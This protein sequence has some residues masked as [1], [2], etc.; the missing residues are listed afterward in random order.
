MHSRLS[1]LA[2]A[3]VLGAAAIPSAAWGQAQV[4]QSIAGTRLDV[5]ARG[6]VNRVPDI[7]T[8]STGVTTRAATASAAISEAA[9][10]MAAIRAELKRSGIADRDIQTSNLSLNPQYAYAEGRAPRLTGYEASNQL[11]VRFRNIAD[12]G[13]VI[14]ALVRAGANQINGP[15]LSIEDP[16]SALDEARAS[17][18]ARG[19]AEAALYARALGMRVVRV[20]SVSEGGGNYPVPPPMPVMMS[21]ERSSDSKI[22]PG[23]QKLSVALMMTFELQ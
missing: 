1:T 16:Q 6:E 10:R 8:V 14:D 17:A 18:V 22:D 7:A 23:E 2:A 21:A 9:S 15:N 13:K 20:V 3:L 5:V 11:S 12:S 19:R 4:N